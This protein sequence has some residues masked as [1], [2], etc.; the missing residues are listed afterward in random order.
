MYAALFQPDCVLYIFCVVFLCTINSLQIVDV[1]RAT[2]GGFS[3]GHLVVE[4]REEFVGKYLHIAFQNEN[5]VARTTDS[6]VTDREGKPQ[7]GTYVHGVRLLPL[8]VHC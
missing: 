3:L 2:E 4:G 6:P 5:L 7:P 8:C 1:L